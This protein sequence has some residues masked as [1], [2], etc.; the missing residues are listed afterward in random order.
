M[1]EVLYEAVKKGNLEVVAF[2]LECRK[3]RK[4]DFNLD[5]KNGDDGEVLLVLAAEK[6][7]LMVVNALLKAGADV[8]AKG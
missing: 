8:N 4:V 5:A 7:H 2:L 3:E 6:G 1:L